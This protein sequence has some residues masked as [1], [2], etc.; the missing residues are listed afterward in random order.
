[1]IQ[2][3]LKKMESSCQIVGAK[4]LKHLTKNTDLMRLMDLDVADQ[5]NKVVLTHR[6]LAENIG[7]DP[8]TA[9]EVYNNDETS[10]KQWFELNRLTNEAT[11]TLP[12]MEVAMKI[13]DMTPTTMFYQSTDKK[14]DV[15][16]R[17]ELSSYQVTG[18][19]AALSLL[20]SPLHYGIIGD[21]VGL[22]KTRLALATIYEFSKLLQRYSNSPKLTREMMESNYSEVFE[23]HYPLPAEYTWPL[24]LDL[25]LTREDISNRLRGPH[26]PTLV[27]FPA[28]AS[29]TWTNEIK[30]FEKAGLLKTYFWLSDAQGKN[31]ANS[32]R[33]IGRNAGD[34]RDFIDGL[35]STDPATARIVILSS[36]SCFAQRTISFTAE[37]RKTA[38]T[39]KKKEEE[40]NED[41]DDEDTKN[42]DEDTIAIAFSKVKGYFQLIV[43]DE[44][45]RWKNITAICHLSVVKAEPRYVLALTATPV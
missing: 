23:T 9:E 24:P 34:V 37:S 36:L 19:V 45:H 11:A 7:A 2:Y 26:R 35:D 13:L 10:Q 6:Q 27:L 21:D 18:I 15:S 43:L 38:K 1:M 29:S 22:G 16:T 8:D 5:Y 32:A 44:A 42:I 28:N 14:D 17:I 31:A 20:S 12:D 41:S 3:L 33:S 39:T 25:D 30:K 40:E 4:G